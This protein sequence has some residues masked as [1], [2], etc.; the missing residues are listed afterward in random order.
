MK[1]LIIIIIVFMFSC[2]RECII[3]NITV[4]ENL[5]INSNGYCELISDALNGD[6]KS[7][8][9]ICL[10]EFHGSVGYDHGYVLVN[11]IN[12]IGTEQFMNSLKDLDYNQ[13]QILKSYIDIGLIYEPNKNDKLNEID[14]NKINLF[15]ENK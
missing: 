2:Q 11:L 12:K 5:I 6:K 15:L 1:Y 9:K 3:D 13:K 7:I 4:S 10:M 8:E 14:F